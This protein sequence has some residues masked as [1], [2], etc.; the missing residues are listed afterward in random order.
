[1]IHCLSC[2]LIARLATS[3]QGTWEEWEETKLPNETSTQL[4]NIDSHLK[5]TQMNPLAVKEVNIEGTEAKIL[6]PRNRNYP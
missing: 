6:K 2:L 3:H 1:M 5:P 4:E